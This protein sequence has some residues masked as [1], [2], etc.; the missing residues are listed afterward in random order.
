MLWNAISS[1]CARG[2]SSVFVWLFTVVQSPI[3]HSTKNR[4]RKK[5]DMLHA[6]VV[7][8]NEVYLLKYFTTISLLCFKTN[9]QQKN[10]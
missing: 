10:K 8:S 2:F 7:E 9:S 6:T 3:T 1:L 4:T 5:T